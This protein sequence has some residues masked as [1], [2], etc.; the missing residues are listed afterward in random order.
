MIAQNGKAS[1]NQLN[2]EDFN[3]ANAKRGSARGFQSN[4]VQPRPRAAG[5]DRM[6]DPR[7]GGVLRDKTGPSTPV[8]NA[9][10]AAQR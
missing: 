3:M 9:A 6:S 8:F 4:A 2:A 1:A 10:V 5:R 7:T